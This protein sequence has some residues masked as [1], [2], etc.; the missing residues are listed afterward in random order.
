MMFLPVPVLL[1]IGAQRQYS[2]YRDIIQLPTSI[3]HLN[4]MMALADLN[5]EQFFFYKRRHQMV[6]SLCDTVQMSMST[7]YAKLGLYSP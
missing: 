5:A 7:V 3:Q 6:Y 1:G 2:E 4:K